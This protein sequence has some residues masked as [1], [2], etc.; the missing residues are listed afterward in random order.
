MEDFFRDL[1]ANGWTLIHAFPVGDDV[2]PDTYSFTKPLN[3]QQHCCYTKQP[4]VVTLR[5]NIDS[6]GQHVS[7]NCKM[8]DQVMRVASLTYE[9]LIY[10][11]QCPDVAAVESLLKRFNVFVAATLTPD[12]LTG[13]M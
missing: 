13:F 6:A 1:D 11:D 5:F 7:M 3:T 9:R 8:Q 4:P 2:Q 12:R 10:P